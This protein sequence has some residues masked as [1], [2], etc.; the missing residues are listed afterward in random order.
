LSNLK[1]DELT[2]IFCLRGLQQICGHE[3]ENISELSSNVIE[4]DGLGI[5]PESQNVTYKTDASLVDQQSTG[6]KRAAKLYPLNPEDYCEWAGK[7]NQGGGKTPIDGCGIRLDSS[8]GMQSC[9][10]HGPDKNTLNNE[11]GNVHR[12]CT[13]CHNFGIRKTIKIISP[14]RLSGIRSRFAKG[15]TSQTV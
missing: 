11:A 12:I 8:I 3:N 6:R 1:K 2:C 15:L 5:D 7:R 14:A 10:H 4:S 9:R 13:P